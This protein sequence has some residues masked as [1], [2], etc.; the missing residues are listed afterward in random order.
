MRDYLPPD[1]ELLACLLWD[2]FGPKRPASTL[3]EVASR[4]P[5]TEQQIASYRQCAD[6]I[7]RSWQSAQ[8]DGA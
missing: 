5:A 8:D 1:A 3:A 2:H 4:K 6:D 7:I